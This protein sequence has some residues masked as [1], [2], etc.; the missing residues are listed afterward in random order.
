ML[1]MEELRVSSCFVALDLAFITFV[2]LTG[3]FSIYS[4]VHAETRRWVE[5]T[6]RRC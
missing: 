1:E 6:T 5:A 2:L 4:A 3:L